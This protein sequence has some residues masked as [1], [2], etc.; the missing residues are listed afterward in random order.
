MGVEISHLLFADD[1]LLFCEPC[2]NQLIYLSWVLFSF[3]AS[4][5]LKIDLDK[6]E[7]IPM[8]EVLMLRS[9]TL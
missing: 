2:S 3:E 8:G 5:G 4:L 1:T 9:L 6:S 7:M